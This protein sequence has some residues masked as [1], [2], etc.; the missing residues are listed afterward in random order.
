VGTEL[1][2]VINP[3]WSCHYDST[4]TI[5]ENYTEILSAIEEVSDNLYNAF[6]VDTVATAIGLCRILKRDTFRFCAV[7]M[8]KVLE[9]LKPADACLQLRETDMNESTKVMDTSIN[10]I[11]S[12]R[13]DDG[14]DALMLK[15]KKLKNKKKNYSVCK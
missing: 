15:F 5:V 8:K 9:I 10:M 3:R 11:R 13:S 2:S 6:D 12:L 14:F 4:V 7:L 1:K